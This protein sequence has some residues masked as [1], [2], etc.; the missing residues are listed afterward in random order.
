MTRPERASVSVVVVMVTTALLL[1]A[2]LVFDGGR[3]LTAHRDADA[4]ASAA[5]RAGGQSV[6]ETGLRTGS[7]TPLD[8]SDAKRRVAAYLADTD[9]TGT[10]TVV[11]DTVTVTVSRTETLPLLSL[12]GLHDTRISGTGTARAVR[13]GP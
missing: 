8:P 13:G 4:V 9:F 6:D 10:A 3:V 1:V 11:G 7:G 5:A 2:G 12:A